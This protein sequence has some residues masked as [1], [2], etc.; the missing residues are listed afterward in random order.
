MRR[1]FGGNSSFIH[2]FHF[3]FPLAGDHAIFVKRLNTVIRHRGQLQ[4]TL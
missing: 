1:P 4:V 2:G 3:I